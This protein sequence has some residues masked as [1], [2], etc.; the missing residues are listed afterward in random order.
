M[1]VEE[2][3]ISKLISYALRHEPARFQLEL[4]ES[5]FVSLDELVSKLNQ[6]EQ[7]DLTTEAV[8]ALLEKS[9]KKRWE[10]QGHLIRAVYG[11]S[12]SQKIIKQAAK[13]PEFLYHGTAHKFVD[14]I[15]AQ[16]LLPKDR[17]YVHL[18]QEIITAIDVG[19][20]RD[21]EPVLLEVL[22][23]FAYENGVVFY[24]EKGGIWLSEP[25]PVRYLR[26]MP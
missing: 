22:A 17:Q 24:Q 5:G 14:R 23:Q 9:D 7:V 18:S 13:P 15:L 19:K 25:I 21:H 2:E 12:L 11:H 1:L 16:G 10:I 8:V 26:V 20:R 6:V 4:D 3:K